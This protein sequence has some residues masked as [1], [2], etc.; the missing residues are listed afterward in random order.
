MLPIL[1]IQTEG[2]A[3]WI[4]SRDHRTGLT[5]RDGLW[6]GFHKLGVLWLSDSQDWF[7]VSTSLHFENGDGLSVTEVD[8]E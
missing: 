8:L 3:H 7:S 2:S 4:P 1:L 6:E 5:R